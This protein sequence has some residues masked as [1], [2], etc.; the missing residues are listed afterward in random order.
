MNIWATLSLILK[1][2]KYV[3]QFVEIIDKGIR[4]GYNAYELN[5]SLNR[6][7]RGFREVKTVQDAA[8]SAR[9]INDSFRK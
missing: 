2:W 8:S 7:E 3:V 5:K 4:N 1:N 9:D 6:L